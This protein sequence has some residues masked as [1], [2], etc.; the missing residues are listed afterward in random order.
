MHWIIL[1]IAGLFEIVWA[2][3]LKNSQSFTRL[4]PSVIAVISYIASLYFL[5]LAMRHLPLG[6]S[7]AVWTGI[8]II[9]TTVIGIVF[10]HEPANA[11]R[12]LCLAAIFG[13]I[14]GLRL[15]T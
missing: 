9:G 6:T 11:V 7:Y 15:N 4:W 13:G 8:G 3:E 1:T 14:V 2:V 5:A 12:L 10:Y